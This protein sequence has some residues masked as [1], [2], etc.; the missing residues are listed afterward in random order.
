MEVYVLVPVRR[1][2]S[3]IVGATGLLVGAVLSMLLSCMNV[4]FIFLA[5]IFAV[6]WFLF[7][8]RSNKEYEYSYFDGDM[9]FSKI[10]NKSRRKTLATYS[11]GDVIQIAPEGD[12]SVYR[13][14]N[15]KSV[16]VKDYSSGRKEAPKY[17]M[18][19]S[20]ADKTLLIKFEP[21]EQY[22][23]AIELKYKQKVIRRQGE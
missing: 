14:E 10:M 3:T 16:T 22:L 7:T 12:R 11:M 19:L 2:T 9:R 6:L 8:F 23:N 18:V 4:Y 5:M 13:Y 17:D 1:G 21:D 15:D 20:R